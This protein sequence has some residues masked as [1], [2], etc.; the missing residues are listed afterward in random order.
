M[1]EKYFFKKKKKK[2]IVLG[3]FFRRVRRLVRVAPKSAVGWL[4]GWSGSR[5][6]RVVRRSGVRAV[7]SLVGCVVKLRTGQGLGDWSEPYSANQRDTKCGGG[8]LRSPY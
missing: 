6:S 8:A 1:R 4:V 7:G 3:I 2:I 5:V